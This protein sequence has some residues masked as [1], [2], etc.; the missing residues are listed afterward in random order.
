M[1]SQEPQYTPPV[2]SLSEVWASTTSSCSDS[3]ASAA[4]RDSPHEPPPLEAADIIAFVEAVNCN[5]PE[6]GQL[7]TQVPK[8]HERR[9]DAL[10]GAVK[11]KS[12]AKR[13]EKITSGLVG[14]MEAT[15][16]DCAGTA[17]DIQSASSA[18]VKPTLA[19]SLTECQGVFHE[20]VLGLLEVSFPVHESIRNNEFK[21]SDAVSAAC[22]RNQ[23]IAHLTAALGQLFIKGKLNPKTMSSP[24]D[25]ADS[26]A[27]EV[28]KMLEKS[29]KKQ[30][31]KDKKKG[32]AAAVDVGNA[33]NMKVVKDAWEQTEGRSSGVLG[34]EVWEGVCWHRGIFLFS[35]I[36]NLLGHPAS[37]DGSGKDAASDEVAS[38]PAVSRTLFLDALSSFH[39]ML[40]AQ[41]PIEGDQVDPAL[42]QASS[43]GIHR[44]ESARMFYH[45]IYTSMHL[46]GLKHLAELSYWQWK[47]GGKAVADAKLAAIVNRKFA[48]VV[49]H[50]M[51]HAGWTAD[52]EYERILEMETTS[53]ASS[54]FSKGL[55]GVDKKK[56]TNKKGKASSAGD[57]EGASELAVSST[58]PAPD[59]AESS[60]DED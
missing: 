59:G 30:K 38:P 14:D 5:V 3:T 41:G 42:W 25:S 18:S 23:K 53:L 49:R 11:I 47:H 6:W 57:A 7:F 34:Q 8:D 33:P 31:K 36:E 39:M 15:G 16:E 2:G 58:A 44:D 43:D 1:V 13:F 17:D 32:A 29:M 40:T 28:L 55:S 24:N 60:S 50:V 52:I 19:A 4:D 9:K 46:R 12:A 10:G 48:H 35:Y 45:G 26:L 20:I 54:E 21:D 22:T 37:S 56:E 27:P 51:P